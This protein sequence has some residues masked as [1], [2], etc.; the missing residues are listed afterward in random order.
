MEFKGRYLIPASADT[1]WSAINDPQVLSSVHPWM[2]AHGEDGRDHFVAAA[3]IRIGPVKATFKAQI[4]LGD[5]DPPRHC[6]LKGEGQG[7]VAGFARGEADVTLEQDAAGTWLSYRAQATIGG[8]LAQ[9]GQRLIDGAAKQLADEFF[10]RFA[11][12]VG[13]QAQASATAAEEEVNSGPDIAAAHAT[14]AQADLA[15]KRSGVAPEIWVVVLLASIAALLA[16]FGVI[17]R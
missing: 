3:T 16:L 17:T 11:A 6:T 9:I 7:G 1:V 8:K 10:S 2:R 13:S 5:M 15:T 12:A 4:A 14:S